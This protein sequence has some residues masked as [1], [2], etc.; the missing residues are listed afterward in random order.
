M[1]SETTLKFWFPKDWWQTFRCLGVA[2]EHGPPFDYSFDESAKS[3]IT[4]IYVDKNIY[5]ILCPSLCSCCCASHT[6][7][8][9]CTPI[10]SLN[11]IAF[12]HRAPSLSLMDETSFSPPSFSSSPVPWN[13]VSSAIVWFFL[14][15]FPAL[16]PFLK[17]FSWNGHSV[18][19]FYLKSRHYFYVSKT[20]PPVYLFCWW[21][22]DFGQ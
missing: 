16:L 11:G 7:R 8:T 14:Y 13:R 5:I 18:L 22:L 10:S 9:D 1:A 4:I 12:S 3:V 19:S 15:V 17:V 21:F 6:S 2:S 20:T